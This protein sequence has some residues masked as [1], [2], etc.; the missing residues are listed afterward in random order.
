MTRSTHEDGGKT[1]GEG[2]GSRSPSL[3]SRLRPDESTADRPNI[4]VVVLDTTRAKD[5]IPTDPA[6]TPMLSALSDSGTEYTN[7][8]TS[9]P[10]TLPSHA[11]MFTGTYPSTHGAHGDHT[12]LDGS[13]PTLA[14]VFGANGYETVGVSNNTWI[15]EEFG[16]ARG[17]ETFRKGWQYV[18]TD[19]DHGSVIRADGSA[20]KLKAAT[21]ALGAGNPLVTA[22]NIA[23]SEFIKPNGD[24]GAA[25]TTDWIETWLGDREGHRPFFLFANYIEPHAEYRP[26]REYAEPFL[27]DGADYEDAMAVRQ[28][29]RAFDAG[30]YDLTD[31][32]RAL[33][34]ALYRG[35]IAYLDHH[36]DRLTDALAAETED[37]T[38]LVVV[39]DH[40]ENIGEHGLFG[41][42]Y[43]VYDT[44]L[45]VPLV[46]HGGA[47]AGGSTTDRLVGTLDLAPTLLDAAGIDA[48]RVREGFQGR[49]FHPD[50]DADDRE[51]V[52]AEYITPQPSVA[53]L[54]T[55]FGDLPERLRESDRALR[56]IRT[57]DE[58]LVRGSNGATELYRVADDPGETTDLAS[59][60]P[61]Q[62]E[63]LERRLDRWRESVDPA[64]ASEEVAMTDATKERLADLG[65]L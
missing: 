50:A 20:T 44:L 40:G 24:D 64:T 34:R 62:V 35:E 47:F 39:G 58:K 7:A 15:T 53:T 9:A 6:V 19:T 2:D 16:F 8:F 55:R 42:Q 3:A 59:E 52:V 38:V 29:P 10:W 56:A 4:A 11:S 63:R 12:H 31:H 60:R 13:L 37:E 17:F 48:P 45:H 32:E 33:L 26:P 46:V 27:P 22:A 21:A 51:A 41:H 36:L 18:Q 30:Q 54:E 5:T 43:N 1:L 49:S 65:Y 25:R 23:Y 57:A 61:D 28:D 14:E